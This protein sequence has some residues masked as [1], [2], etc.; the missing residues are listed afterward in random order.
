M[1]TRDLNQIESK[2]KIVLVPYV[3][4]IFA[5]HLADV[6][7]KEYPWETHLSVR[8]PTAGFHLVGV[9]TP[10]LQLLLEQRTADIRWVVQ[11]AGS[12][13]IIT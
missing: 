3:E 9:E 13:I 10:E 6:K 12:E 7:L 4:L 8:H 2:S 11:L 5:F 1:A